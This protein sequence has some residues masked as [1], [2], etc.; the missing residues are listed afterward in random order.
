MQWAR[1]LTFGKGDH[2]VFLQGF[3]FTTRSFQF[4]YIKPPGLCKYWHMASCVNSVVDA[5]VFFVT[6]LVWCDEVRIFFVNH[7][8]YE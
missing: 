7:V 1:P 2:S 8:P 3:K 4:F 6:V 5:A